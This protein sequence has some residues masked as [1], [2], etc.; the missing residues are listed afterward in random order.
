M[1]FTH[2]QI[3]VKGRHHLQYEVVSTLAQ[4]SSLPPSRRKAI[5]V[6]FS[7]AKGRAGM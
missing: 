4:L 7:R 6:S 3:D 5:E 1:E 2:G